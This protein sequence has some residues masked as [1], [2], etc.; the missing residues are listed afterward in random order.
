MSKSNGG[1]ARYA[2][3][4]SGLADWRHL[5][6]LEL[7][8]RT[9]TER[10]GFER[11]R[12]FVLIDSGRP[13]PRR[14]PFASGD[15]TIRE[16]PSDGSPFTLPLTGPGT[17]AAFRATLAK[18]KRRLAHDD[19]LFIHT[20]GHGGFDTGPRGGPYLSTFSR[21][22]PEGGRYFAWQFEHD[23]RALNVRYRALLVMM[24]QCCSGG[25]GAP[26]LAGSTA[27]ATSVACAASAEGYSYWSEDQK[28]NNF[29]FD[30]ME[31]HRRAAAGTVVTSLEAFQY[32]LAKVNV[33][34][35]PNYHSH[36]APA[37]DEISLSSPLHA[38]A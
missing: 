11:D 22:S 29:V 19:L 8:C 7:S 3:L 4:F 26:V 17:R 12:V 21:S 33:F 15:G 13:Q 2:I 6:D 24:G 18:L 36:P 30:W 34:D 25:F 32:A 28:W 14:G 1:G 35:T 20:D 10:C 27:A 9:L 31:A 5:N 16:W 37:A 23:L 38:A